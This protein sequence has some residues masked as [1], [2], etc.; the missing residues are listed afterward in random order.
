M[1]AILSALFL[2]CAFGYAQNE[3]LPTNL[4][5]YKFEEQTQFKPFVWKPSFV[6]NN[7]S[8]SSYN[9]V[10]GINNRYTKVGENY[11]LS[12]TKTFSTINIMDLNRIDSYNPYGTTN[13]GA[14]I[15][16]GT[17]NLILQKN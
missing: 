2:V 14:A 13:F 6:K 16:M 1:K 8:F 9:S 5:T 7:Y 3:T 4:K 11:F 17:I 15:I 12:N 10:T